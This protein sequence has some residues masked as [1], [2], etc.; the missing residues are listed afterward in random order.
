VAYL[1]AAVT[2]AAFTAAGAFVW[3]S[4]K[5]WPDATRRHRLVYAGIAVMVVVIA[6]SSL[7]LAAGSS[8]ARE[9]RVEAVVLGVLLLSALIAGVAM[10]IGLAKIGLAERRDRRGG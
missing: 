5:L 8:G 9:R 7:T 3:F 6:C 4:R 2:G 10:S 1:S